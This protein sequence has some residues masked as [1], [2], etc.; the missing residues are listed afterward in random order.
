MIDFLLLLSDLHVANT[1]LTEA[2]IA[3]K[4]SERDPRA[5]KNHFIN[6]PFS[7]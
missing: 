7:F 5:R 4:V 6:P 3:A 2:V 1:S